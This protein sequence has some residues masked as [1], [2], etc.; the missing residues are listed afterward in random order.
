MLRKII[1]YL[2]L[3]KGLK[4]ANN[5]WGMI[6]AARKVASEQDLPFIGLV[7]HTG[8]TQEYLSILPFDEVYSMKLD[9]KS[10]FDA[11]CHVHAFEVCYQELGLT[12]G[13]YLFASHPLYQ[14]T[15]IR[16]AARMDGAVLTQA[17]EIYTDPMANTVVKRGIYHDKANEWVSFEGV[18]HQFVT[19]DLAHFYADP[20]QGNPINIKEI[21]LKN[22][23]NTRIQL[24]SER[25]LSWKELSLTEA[26]FVIGVGRGVSKIG[27]MNG[28]LQ[29][30]EL[31]N[32]PIGGSKV[33]DELGLIPREK[34]IG[35]SGIAIDEADVYIA[36]GIS[37]SSQHL[38]GIKGV[39]HVIAINN[40]PAAPIHQRSTIGIVGDYQVVVPL[41][42]QALQQGEEGEI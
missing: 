19:L 6:E 8:M 1:C 2:A 12:E 31:L 41:L 10:W 38:E 36:I 30:A 37:G 11:F 29:L 7:V 27:D 16:L 25:S 14:E 42:V 3:D 22:P 40:D 35:S 24:I 20:K 5:A 26:R 9:P 32:A 4:V 17:M 13:L 18:K 33:A 28:I 34:R 21:F 15:A 39:K 23:I